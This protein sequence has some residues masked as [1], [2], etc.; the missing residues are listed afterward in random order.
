M[1]EGRCHCTSL[2]WRTPTLPAWL[3]VCTCSFCRRAGVLWGEVA[4]DTAQLRDEAGTATRYLREN[5]TLAFV[6]C[7]A[8]GNLSHWESLTGPVRLKL[9]F[10]LADP[11]LLEGLNVR[12]FDGADSFTYLDT[13]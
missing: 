8:C 1:I 2:S 7:S 9:N 13:P 12:T 6:F 4:A 10:R 11:A 3:S 5:A